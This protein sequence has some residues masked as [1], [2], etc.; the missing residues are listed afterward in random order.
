MAAAR[1]AMR[2]AD[3]RARSCPKPACRRRRA[4][5]ANPFVNHFSRTGGCPV[6]TWEEWEMIRFGISLAMRSA[7][8]KVDIVRAGTGES[9]EAVWERL[10]L[11]APPARWSRHALMEPMR[12]SDGPGNGRRT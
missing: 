4:C 12:G 6:T 8:A 2:A 1:K 7:F 10:S 3:A 11:P 5:T 9:F